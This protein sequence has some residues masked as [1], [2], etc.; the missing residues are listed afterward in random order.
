[1]QDAW[2]QKRIPLRSGRQNVHRSFQPETF[3]MRLTINLCILIPDY[4]HIRNSFFKLF[5]LMRWGIGFD[6]LEAF[7]FSQD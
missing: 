5:I 2:R 1:M 7:E 4:I 3:I 6:A